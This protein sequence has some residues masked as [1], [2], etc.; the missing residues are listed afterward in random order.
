MTLQRRW[1]E[2]VSGRRRGVPA[3]LFR[4]LLA[5]ATVPYILGL[6]ANLALYEKG[7]KARTRPPIPV[8]SVGNITLGGTGKTTATRRLS[9]DLLARGVRP[10]IVLRGHGRRGTGVLLVSDGRS[11]LAA[12]SQSGDEAAMLARTTDGALVA[13]GTRRERV[14]DTLADAG[15]QVALLDDGFQYFRMHRSVDLVLVDA[16]LDLGDARV[17]PRGRLREPLNHL[18]RATHLLVTHADL[19]PRRQVVRTVELLERHAPHAPVMLARHASRSVRP[20]DTPGETGDV[21][22]AGRRVLVMCAV[23]NPASF[24]GLLLQH[25]AEVVGRVTFPDHHHYRPEDWSRVREALRG[26]GAELI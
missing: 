24:E 6:K 19:A 13:V 8:A 14:I 23:G 4:G 21:D 2:I 18:G 9:Q 22:L 12:V 7:L 5:A 11:P 20:M 17:F 15:A 10:G 26:A 1:L 3:G 25:G 16:T